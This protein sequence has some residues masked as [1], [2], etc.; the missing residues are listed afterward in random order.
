MSR[1]RDEFQTMQSGCF[2][3]FVVDDVGA[4]AHLVVDEIC[5]WRGPGDTSTQLHAFDNAAAIAAVRQEVVVDP[6]RRARVAAFQPNAA[7]GTCAGDGRD[8]TGLIASVDFVQT[9]AP[10]TGSISPASRFSAVDAIVSHS[11]RGIN[12]GPKC[13]SNVLHRALPDREWSRTSVP[14]IIACRRILQAL[15][16]LQNLF[17]SPTVHAMLLPSCKVVRPGSHGDAR[18]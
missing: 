4:R 14:F 8:D 5:E 9:V 3:S 6:R 13:Q 17:K 2:E 12:K 7:E 18:H 1:V 11:D 16:G 15:L 10:L